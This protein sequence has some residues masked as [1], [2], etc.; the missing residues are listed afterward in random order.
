MSITGKSHQAEVIPSLRYVGSGL[1]SAS[2]IPV[3]AGAYSVR[4]QLG[5]RDILCGLGEVTPPCSPFSLLVTPGKTVAEKSE[6]ESPSHEKMDYL[7]E[8][9]A[10][11]FGYF[12]IQAKD[13]YG[14]NQVVGGDTFTATFSLSTNKSIVFSG[15]VEDGGGGT[16]TVRYT[17]PLV[18]T[19]N[20]NVTSMNSSGFARP[21]SVCTAAIAP[22]VFDRIYDGVR[23][24]NSPSFCSSVSLHQIKVVHGQFSA[25]SSTYSAYG[26]SSLSQVVANSVGSFVISSRD[27]FGNLRVGEG[28][29]HFIGY[30]SGSDDYFLVDFNYSGGFDMSKGDGMRDETR[31]SGNV[32]YRTSSA[33]D[34]LVS[35]A[36]TP[37]YFRLSFGA[38]MTLDIA[39]DVSASALENILE[40]LHDYR[41]DVRVTRYEPTATTRKWSITFLT[42]LDIWQSAPDAGPNLSSRLTAHPPST[43]KLSAAFFNSLSILRLGSKGLYPVTFTLHR[44]GT[45]TMRITSNGVDITGSPRLISVSDGPV[46]PTASVAMG[47]GLVGG[48]AGEL[49]T[50]RVQAMD[51]RVPAVQSL[52]TSGTMVPFTAEVQE[53][54]VPKQPTVVTLLFRGS[55]AAPLTLSASATYSALA[56]ALSTIS[57]V[58]SFDLLDSA[59]GNVKTMSSDTIGASVRVRFTALVGDLPS[60]AF[61]V[62]ADGLSISEVQKGDAPFRAEV[63]VLTCVPSVDSFIFTFRG[64]RSIPVPFTT[65]VASAKSVLDNLMGSPVSFNKDFANSATGP[66]CTGSRVYLTFDN[67]VGPVETLGVISLKSG[68]VSVSTDEEV[69]ALTG[70]APIFGSFSLGYKG[71]NTT[72]IPV[73]AS[74]DEVKT[75]IMALYSV[76]EVVVTKDSYG[77]PLGADGLTPLYQNINPYPGVFSI[78]TIS[79]SGNCSGNSMGKSSG[80][81]PTSLGREPLFIVNSSKLSFV[82]S[83]VLHQSSPTVQA[84]EYQI[85][86]AG[87][88]RM[89]FDDLN[90]V[91]LLLFSRGTTASRIDMVEQQRLFCAAPI[92]TQVQF[93]LQL[94]NYSVKLLSTY[95]VA[96]ASETIVTALQN[97][98][99]ELSFYTDNLG[100]NLCS[101][102][103]STT[104]FFFNSPKS[105]PT[106]K[107]L[108]T[109]SNCDRAC[110]IG[111][112]PVVDGVEYVQVVDDSPGLFE[113]G[114]T[115]TVQGIYDVRVKLHGV[116]VSTDLSTGVVVTPGIE[117]SATSTHS[118]A[119]VEPL[120]LPH[121]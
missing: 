46:D 77:V 28:T 16:Y 22:F 88:Q 4:I 15:K 7:R 84:S 74:A 43:P 108:N 31:Q 40:A 29:S 42:M 5:Q 86:F 39:Y 110:N 111:V 59:T 11:E 51:T 61:S 6:A 25:L 98:Q 12:Y 50:V 78:W 90:S 107:I 17:L 100:A 105:L 47:Q 91:S 49:L 95:T 13:S 97:Q 62:A 114:Y 104:N 113:I 2:Y 87:N 120:P 33:V 56:S 9:V 38:R 37:G 85:G 21:V 73:S 53:I 24:Y 18:G 119:Q 76:G 55:A 54:L 35:T 116:D 14:N 80:K 20:V 92:G 103:G 81:C 115:P 101:P 109:T 36:V 66:L 112:F 67:F 10:G 26:N 93:F 44:A 96:K 68:V 70:I 118:M 52:V 3:H 79:F 60:L 94:M 99:P 89:T 1:F 57:L 32:L 71:E 27:V 102:A 72:D 121:S 34:E 58:G 75:A 23:P 82:H 69:G 106:M 65:S 63:Q 117:Y 30:G 8:A 45:Y 19:Y 64:A 41:L 48:V 83:P